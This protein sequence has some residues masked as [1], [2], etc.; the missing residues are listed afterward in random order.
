MIRRIPFMLAAAALS[1]AAAD[2]PIEQFNTLGYGTLSGHLQTLSM[3]R[4]F[5]NGANAHSTTLGI[6]LDYR[7]N[8]KEGWGFGASYIGAGVL[9]SMDYETSADPGGTLVGNGRVNVLNEAFVSYNMEGFGLSN[10]VAA[11]GRK[12]NN[13]EV[14]RSDAFR[15]KPRSIEAAALTTK[16]IPHTVLIAGH[17]WRLSN[18]IDAG[19][20][21]Q[22]NNFGDVFSPTYDT[23]GVTWGEALYTGIEHL[24]VAAF[25]AVA[26]DVVNLIGARVKW[27]FTEKTALL[28]CCRNETDIGRNDG[29]GANAFGLAVAQDVGGVSLE[30][31]YF[32]VSGDSLEFQETSTG[33]NHP[34]GLSM[35]IFSRQFS[36]GADTFYAKAVTR[37]EKTKTALY[38][39][40]NYTQHDTGKAGAPQRYGQ[41]LN[42]M[43]S[44]PIPKFDSLTAA[45]KVGVGYYDGINGTDDTFGT[46]T[47]LLVTYNF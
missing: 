28:A 7:S 22:F 44:Q 5:D 41:E 30:G 34:L 45:L 33:I 1:C 21:W 15:Q 36:G 9:N 26:W 19:D 10:T 12:V 17:A 39:L 8:E 23:D 38:G 43:A 4:D 20:R 29:H 25:D 42:V 32:G 47:R 35:M 3:Y 31:G 2:S 24:E 13:G 37:L 18:W 6:R 40:Y 27:N 11:A 46:D 16:D 14:F